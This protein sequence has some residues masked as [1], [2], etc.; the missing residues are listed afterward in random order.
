[1]NPVQV[2]TLWCMLLLVPG[3]RAPRRGSPEEA[4]FYYGTFPP[5][6]SIPLL[7]CSSVCLSVSVSLPTLADLL[8]SLVF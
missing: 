6:M 8:R 1:M 3:L 7:V 4:S 5:G 2:V